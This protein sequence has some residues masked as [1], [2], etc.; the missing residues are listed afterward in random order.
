MIGNHSVRYA[1]LVDHM[2]KLYEAVQVL[3]GVP[4]GVPGPEWPNAQ[5]RTDLGVRA[6]RPG[7]APVMASDYLRELSRL[8]VTH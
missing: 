4:T 2:R 5:L 1:E 6:S 7:F 8:I 3:R